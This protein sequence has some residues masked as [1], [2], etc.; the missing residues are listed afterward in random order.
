MRR[1][2]DTPRKRVIAVALTAWVAVLVAIQM[3]P[4]PYLRLTPGPMFD[5]LD[6]VD[7]RPVIEIEGARTYPTRG[8]LSM[9]TVTERGGPY[10]ALTLPEAYWGWWRSTA[11]VVPTE[12][13]F[14]PDTS[15]EQARQEGRVAFASSQ[16]AAR[17]AALREVGKP[18]VT[19][20]V[21]IGVVPDA[22]ADGRLEAGD[23]I[24]EVADRPVTMPAQV[25]RRV[26]RTPPGRQV[27]MVARRKGSRIPVAI[28][29]RAN[30]E[31]PGAGY[32][33]IAMGVE[34][35]SPVKVTFHLEDVGGPSAGLVFS[36]GIVDKLTPGDLLDGAAVAGT[37]TMDAD[38]RVG[39]I[40]GIG[41][42]M[43]AARRAGVA[44]FLAPRDNCPQV[45]SDR[46]ADLQ[47]VPVS[48]LREARRVLEQYRSG[49]TDFPGCQ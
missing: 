10:G 27:A 28:P 45:V 19:R 21:V 41:Q 40:G 30:P 42:K 36:L 48:T 37:G 14:P 6:E 12:L 29:V 18:V 31:D 33:G 47:V 15:G 4:M 24:L 25:A 43:A 35:R 7:N 22:P 11:V 16:E 20:P 1:L 44:L 46:P 38:G 2:V 23:T 34:A 26:R 32:I 17:V 49:I 5:V 3:A 39:A 13:I 9:T 8:T